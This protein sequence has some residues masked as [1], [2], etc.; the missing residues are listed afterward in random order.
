M[1]AYSYMLAGLAV[2]TEDWVLCATP[3]DT[4]GGL[5]WQ[6]M[7]GLALDAQS[8][9]AR[10]YEITEALEKGL[11]KAGETPKQIYTPTA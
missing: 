8:M 3:K 11:A 4:A 7:R 2:A 5:N 6:V 9:G 10:P 1:S